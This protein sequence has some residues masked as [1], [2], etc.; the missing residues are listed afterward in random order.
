MDNTNASEFVA[1]ARGLKDRYA[2]KAL[3]ASTAYRQGASAEPTETVAA[4]SPVPSALRR[5]RGS[6]SSASLQPPILDVANEDQD[7][8]QQSPS[9]SEATRNPYAA[10]VAL[11]ESRL[12]SV[13][14]ENRRYQDRDKA[15]SKKL[16]RCVGVLKDVMM[17]GVNGEAM[18][19]DRAS[20]I[21]GVI[22]E[23]AVIAAELSGTTNLTGSNS[24]LNIDQPASPTADQQPQVA[25]S[26]SMPPARDSS[27]TSPSIDAA[28][29]SALVTIDAESSPKAEIPVKAVAKKI[30]LLNFGESEKVMPS[31]H[32]PDI[33]RSA[34]AVFN[35]SPQ[36]QSSSTG[37]EGWTSSLASVASA[38]Q[39]VDIS[40]TVK[41]ATS[42]VKKIF[43]DLF[44]NASMLQNSW[45]SSA[46]AT[47]D[48][49][50]NQ[51]PSIFS[52]HPTPKSNTEALIQE[53][54]RKS[55]AL[56]NAPRSFPPRPSDPLN[57]ISSAPKAAPNYSPTPAISTLDPLA[58]VSV[59]R[60]AREPQPPKK[61]EEAKDNP[62]A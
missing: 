61:L 36:Q 24:S 12:M 46:S 2:A 26:S 16:D 5:G 38:A 30:S 10:K 56:S 13:R 21:E 25:D 6:L 44:D 1:S 57:G 50:S 28:K 8:G 59:A 43:S 29:A 53:G 19:A 39:E 60:V 20:E 41:E 11:L 3:E 9:M 37:L 52:S 47:A 34:A 49:R 7:D 17:G 22:D 33:A 15:I 40:A 32:R 23:L 18:G 42:S 27:E 51:V 31:R 54:Y 45:Q 58:G 4:K 14:Q 55:A 48:G 35:S 62:L